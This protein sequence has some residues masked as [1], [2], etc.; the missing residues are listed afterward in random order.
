MLLSRHTKSAGKKERVR[1][2]SMRKDGAVHTHLK[3]RTATPHRV[4]FFVD[5]TYTSH[6]K[7]SK[8]SNKARSLSITESALE[9]PC[10]SPV[11]MA[12]L[13]RSSP[14]SHPRNDSPAL[15]A[16]SWPPFARAALEMSLTYP[17]MKELRHVVSCTNQI[18]LV[19]SATVNS[20]N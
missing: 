20:L 18:F 12:L 14:S 1:Q 10:G 13:T 16:L 8:G 17:E 6:T 3:F 5:L 4:L 11:K 15:S 7:S 9:L 19:S 2:C